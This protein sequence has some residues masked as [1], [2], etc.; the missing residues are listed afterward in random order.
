MKVAKF[1][2]PNGRDG[3]G[4]ITDDTL[5]PCQLQGGQYKNL[6]EILEADAPSEV[7]NFLCDGQT[8]IPLKQT[9]LLP[10]IDR[11]EVW[12]AGVTYKRSRTARMEESDS[13][14][15]CYDRVYASPRPELFFKATAHRVAGHMQ[16]LRIRKDSQWNVPEPEL[17]LVLNSR[18][19]LVGYTIG[20]D[21]SSRDIEGDNP[22]YLPQAK[23]YN[24]CCGLG[25]W[26]TLEP[27]M[28]PREEIGIRL[29]IRREH[30]E[31][32]HGNTSVLQMAR[33]FET[34]ISWLKRDNS[35]PKGAF[36]LTGTGIV[37]DASFTLQPNDEVEIQIDG[38]GSLI[39]KII[40]G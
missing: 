35:F 6:F 39:N 23:V 19:S 5:I 32:Y 22:L 38:I 29:S 40:Q 26:I 30:K 12:A 15:D 1:R 18:M 37:P 13:A 2:L 17:A 16:Y 11:Q 31:V 4:K 3:V 28:P 34:L 21:M 33:S 10:P 14:A 36:L 24:Q 8:P 7:I 9:N 25:P 27:E 20:N